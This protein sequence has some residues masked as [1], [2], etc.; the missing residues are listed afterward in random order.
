M[1]LLLVLGLVAV[2]GVAG[3]GGWRSV[4]VLRLGGGG[5]T[6]SGDER[7]VLIMLGVVFV[8]KFFQQQ[9]GAGALEGVRRGLVGDDWLQV[10]VLG[11]ETTEE[12][13]HLG[14]LGDGVANAR[15]GS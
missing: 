4:S 2:V 5:A 9:V 15:R 10:A 1:A 12:V 11:V 6:V 13:Q 3:G 7:L 14:R 8:A